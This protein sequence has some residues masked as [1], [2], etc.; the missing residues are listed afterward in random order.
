L[1]DYLG[2]AGLEAL[3]LIDD[4]VVY[5]LQLNLEPLK[6]QDL[7][8]SH[9]TGLC[10]TFLALLLALG[11]GADKGVPLFNQIG[12]VDVRLLEAT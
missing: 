10:S 9:L 5:F 7:V 12:V 4:L 3:I 11:R 2:Y 8:L 6:S 1:I